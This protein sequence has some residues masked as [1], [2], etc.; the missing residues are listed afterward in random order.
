MKITFK[1]ELLK[2]ITYLK[3]QDLEEGDSKD[4]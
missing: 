2:V 4:S 1:H 3:L